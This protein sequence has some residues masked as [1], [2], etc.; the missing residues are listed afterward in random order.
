[1]ARKSRKAII[2]CAITGG[3]VTPSMSPY[4][5]VTPN[6]IAEESIKA[7]DAGAA[8]IHLHAR[9]YE[10]NE[11]YGY[12]DWRPETYMQFLPRI[13]QGCD[14]IVNITTGGASGMTWE[15]RLSGP[16]L[17]SPE[18]T[19][20][21][22]GS[23]NFARFVGAARLRDTAKYPWEVKILEA[24]KHNSYVNTFAMME[25]AGQ[26]L[27]K[28]HGVRFEFECFDIGHLYALKLVR[29]QGWLPEGPIFVQAVLG[30]PGGL[31]GDPQH[32]V[33]FYETARRILGDDIQMSNL[34][35]GKYQMQVAAVGAAL[36]CHVRVGLE[37]S[38]TLGPGKLATS[39]ADQVWQVR[40]IL[41]AMSIEIATP[42]EAREILQTKGADRVNF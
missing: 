26:K 38:L 42:D 14:A 20:F 36:G 6:Q 32:V 3:G 21:N 5:P 18:I 39:N 30:T 24:S 11:M 4:L 33:H 9:H 27:G 23:V 28:E 1:M 12:P 29:D 7:A 13:K 34:G 41:E 25:E 22:S 2:T 16:L 19:S 17:A 8:I 40:K 31:S 37:D 35:V 10:D 15:Q